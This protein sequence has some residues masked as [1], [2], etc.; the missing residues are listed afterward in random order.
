VQSGLFKDEKRMKIR[1]ISALGALLVVFFLY[2]YFGNIGLIALIIFAQLGM[3]FEAKKLVFPD[4]DSKLMQTLFIACSTCVFLSSA[5]IPDQSILFLA[6]VMVLYWAI[7]LFNQ[8]RFNDLIELNRFQT[9]STFC[10]VYIG[11][12]PA[13]AL[14]T[15]LLPQGLIWFLFLLFVVFAGDIGAYLVGKSIGRNKLMISVSPNKT[16]EGSIGGL[17]GTVLASGVMG[18]F[19]LNQINIFWLI[20]LGLIAGVLGQIGDL[21]ES[22]IKRVANVKDSGSI[23][24]GHGGFLDRLDGVLFASPVVL[25]GANILLRFY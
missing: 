16:I 13:L 12:L 5:F 18:H 7:S 2:Q 10:F 24:P 21:F 1:I 15:L 4:H 22:M 25:A 17:L 8:S 19:Y 23:M 3:S 20:V 14:R 6:V 9:L 11:L